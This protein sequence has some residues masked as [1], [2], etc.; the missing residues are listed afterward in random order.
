MTK[1]DEADLPLVIVGTGLTGLCLGHSFRERNLDT[2][3]ID[4]GR[5]PGGRIAERVI[6][7]IVADIGPCWFHTQNELSSRAVTEA[8]N[9]VN[10]RRIESRSLPE[11]VRQRLPCDDGTSSW[12]I[13]GGLRRLT[14][15]L[16]EPL[17][18]RQSLHFRQLER[19]ADHWRLIGTDASEGDK[20]FRLDASGVVLTMPLPQVHQILESSSLSG[21]L[22]PALDSGCEIEYERTDV[23]MF[24]L[25]EPIR[26]LSDSGF[27]EGP[28]GS[29]IRLARMTFAQDTGR[30][31]LTIQ[32]GPEWSL[33]HW[34]DEP[35][36]VVAQI[37]HEADR[38]FGDD[39]EPIE[40]RHHR[41]KFA[42][43]KNA[44]QG[45]AKPL[46]LSDDPPL[47]LAG[48]AFGVSASAPSGLLSAQ[49]SAISTDEL[50]IRLRTSRRSF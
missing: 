22:M 25:S 15:R 38:I 14:A 4:K 11:S 44:N 7:G 3:L 37:L 31:V 34:E 24:L 29:M 18:I 10:A 35:D 13:D 40:S 30:C 26:L 27:Y 21:A 32:A 9:A 36:R 48:E 39:F 50:L 1:R 5:A 8:L 41:W 47:I 28:S 17:T 45:F 2:V 33:D 16:A 20:E 19:C 46:V 23:V 42:R 12:E 6:D 49:A 43:A